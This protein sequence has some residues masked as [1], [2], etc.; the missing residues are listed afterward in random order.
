MEETDL[1]DH[2]GLYV[3]KRWLSLRRIMK[4]RVLF[5]ITHFPFSH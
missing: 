3:E 4:F 1:T 5:L 2:R